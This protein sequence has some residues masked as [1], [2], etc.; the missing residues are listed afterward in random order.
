VSATQIPE[1]QSDGSFMTV[2]AFQTKLAVRSTRRSQHDM[3]HQGAPITDIDPFS[4]QFLTDPYP[5]LDELRELGDVFYFGKYDVWGIARHERI[6]AFLRDPQTYSN[7]A[8]V[9]Y[10]HFGKEQKP[11]R[12]PSIILDADPPEHTAVRRVVARIVSQRAL[13]ELRD[14]FVDVAESLLTDVFKSDS[15]SS[16]DIEAVTELVEPFVLTAFGGALGVGPEARRRLLEYGAITFNAL[17]PENERFVAAMEEATTFRP[18]V[19][20]HT[21]RGA[22]APDG[23][24]A[25]FYQAVDNGLLSEEDAGL[26][27]RAFLSAGVDTTISAMGFLLRRFAVHPDQWDMLRADSSL[28]RPAFDEAVRIDSPVIGFFRTTTCDL[29]LQGA[30]IPGSS[31]V[32]LLFASANRDPRRWDDPERF[33]IT[34][35]SAGHLGFGAGIHNCAGQM[36]ARME[37]EVLFQALATRVTRWESTAPPVPRLNN[38]LRS[39]AHVP[40]RAHLQ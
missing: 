37:A 10:A 1:L 35:R 21:A 4:D 30:A 24:G 22:L 8:G 2:Q 13:N 27:V 16:I 5:F 9:G 7:A 40:L 6:E 33:D 39:Y 20:E 19:V 31:K 12:K 25:K 3:N 32:L 15:A 36:I 23:F 29:T 14:R 34:R 17:G 26:L 28:A 18:W 38:G 11:W